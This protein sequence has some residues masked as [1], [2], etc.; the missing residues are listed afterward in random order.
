M[1]GALA[2]ARHRISRRPGQADATC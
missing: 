1:M 2:R